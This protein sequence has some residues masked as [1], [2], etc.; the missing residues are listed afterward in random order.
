MT[1]AVDLHHRLVEEMKAD[2][3]DGDFE[4]EC[5]F[6]PLPSIIGKHG[7]ERG[8]NL[9]GIDKHKDNAVIL[10]GSLAVNGETQEAIGREKMMTWK[11][12]LED[13]SRRLDARVDYIYMNYAEGTQDVLSS[14][15]EDNVQMA[16]EVAAKY[17]PTGVFQKRVVGGFKLPDVSQLV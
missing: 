2:S 4:T 1:K 16:L 7:E 10:L 15:G 12:D 5:F 8:G 14:Y 13:Y 11:R 3:S 6:Q 17:D 9:L